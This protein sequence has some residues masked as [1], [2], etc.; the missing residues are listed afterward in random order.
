MYSAIKAAAE[1][2]AGVEIA[3]VVEDVLPVREVDPSSGVPTGSIF[4]I[5]RA[6]LFIADVNGTA[7]TALI[8]AVLVALES[9]RACGVQIEVF[10]ASA[11]SVDWSASITLDPGG[12]NFATLSTD[13][14]MI[15]DSMAKYI[16]DLPIGT[17]FD[18]VAA[19]AAILAIWGSAGSGDLTDFV[20]NTPVGNI[21]A[22]TTDKLVPGTIEAD[23]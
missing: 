12:P 22:G 19:K 5:V 21:S 16:R 9:V 17:G 20:I 3:T 7:S 15:E 6:R 11:V 10:G 14:T 2:V 4:K 18:R 1:N 8:D 23:V 13:S